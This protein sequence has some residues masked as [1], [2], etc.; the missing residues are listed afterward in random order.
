MDTIM[1][2]IARY[3]PND[4]L[5]IALYRALSV[6][7]GEGTWIGGSTWIDCVYCKGMV[8]IGRG[9]TISGHSMFIAHDPFEAIEGKPIIVGD[10]AFIGVGT[11][12]LYDVR[13][14][15]HA[16]IG[17]GSVVTRDI[18]PYAIAVGSPARVVGY[19]NLGKSHTPVTERVGSRE[20]AGR[21]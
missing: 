16:I 8:S 20:D 21:A 12:I 19:R 11:I 6:G 2:F 7:I 10:G 1:R 4:W 18:P 17:A 15:H 13:I 3:V 14:G 5:R 9:V